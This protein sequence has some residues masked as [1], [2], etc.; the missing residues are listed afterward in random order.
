MKGATVC[1]YTPEEISQDL[2]FSEWRAWPEL[3]A[4]DGSPWVSNEISRQ[5]ATANRRAA[6]YQLMALAHIS[7][8]AAFAG[9]YAL[10]ARVAS[11]CTDGPLWL[12][13][14]KAGVQ[15]GDLLY[16]AMG[17]HERQTFDVFTESIR[18][19]TVVRP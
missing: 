18:Q 17:E 4:S 7:P 13:S 11:R 8:N 19:G 6:V 2:L 1:E 5:L 15:L 10:L 14:A 16:P 9:R 3:L 12:R